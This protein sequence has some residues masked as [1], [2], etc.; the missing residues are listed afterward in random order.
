MQKT[1]KNTSLNFT[2]AFTMKV[3]V[4]NL[5]NGSI[6]KLIDRVKSDLNLDDKAVSLKDTNKNGELIRIINIQIDFTM[7]DFKEKQE[8]NIIK[9]KNC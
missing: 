9:W 3:N 7:D 6:Q 8:T 2:P 4:S 5:D 1:F